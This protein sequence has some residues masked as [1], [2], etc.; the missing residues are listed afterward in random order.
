MSR[1]QWEQLVKYEEIEAIIC[2]QM[3]CYMTEGKALK[4]MKLLRRIQRKM[5]QLCQTTCV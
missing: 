1:S 2:S 5:E 3:H 4:A